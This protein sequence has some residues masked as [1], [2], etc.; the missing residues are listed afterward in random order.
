MFSDYV[1]I[2]CIFVILDTGCVSISS[3]GA[4]SGIWCTRVGVTDS[5]ATICLRLAPL[6]SIKYFKALN[7]TLV[8]VSF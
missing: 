6:W 8:F 2:R 7:A 3:I 5:A 4:E 1:L